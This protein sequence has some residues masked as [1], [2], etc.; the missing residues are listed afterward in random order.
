MSAPTI[1]APEPHP[2]AWI[3]RCPLCGEAA[4]ICLS[5]PIPPELPEPYW[6]VACS[7]TRHCDAEFYPYEQGT[8]FLDTA[9]RWNAWARRM[10]A[11]LDRRGVRKPLAVG[12]RV[13]QRLLTQP[14]LLKRMSYMLLEDRRAA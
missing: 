11:H 10:T 5:D 6:E 13:P 14:G 8:S 2:A 12:S 9:A 4:E 1:H 3:H 7:S